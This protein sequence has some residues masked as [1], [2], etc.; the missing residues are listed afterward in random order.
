MKNKVGQLKE[1]CNNRNKNRL[2][3]LH[4]CQKQKR[5]QKDQHYRSEG[6][7]NIY[8]ELNKAFHVLRTKRP[9]HPEEVEL[10]EQKK[11][12]L[13][14][15]RNYL[16]EDKVLKFFNLLPE[17]KR[18]EDNRVY[19]YTDSEGVSDEGYTD[20][21]EYKAE[22]KSRN[23]GQKILEQQVSTH[24]TGAAIPVATTSALPS[25]E[26]SKDINKSQS[27]SPKAP[28]G[29]FENEQKKF[30]NIH[31]SDSTVL[32][33][34]RI[35]DQRANNAAKMLETV[36]EQIARYAEKE[37]MTEEDIQIMQRKQA[38]LMEKMSEF[39]EITKRVQQLVGLRDVSSTHL[40]LP[41]K[42]ITIRKS[43]KCVEELPKVVI[44]GPGGIEQVP[45]IIVCSDKKTNKQIT[46]QGHA[47]PDN[48]HPS[49]DS[50]NECMPYYTQQ[51][52]GEPAIQSQ[53]QILEHQIQTFSISQ[54][55]Y[56]IPQGMS[57]VP[58]MAGY[59][60][61]FVPY[62]S[63][64]YPW[65]QSCYQQEM[66]PYAVPLQPHKFQD[67]YETSATSDIRSAPS[68]DQ[69][70]DDSQAHSAGLTDPTTSSIPP[71]QHMESSKHQPSTLEK[72]ATVYT[73]HLQRKEGP[74]CKADLYQSMGLPVPAGS[75]P[76]CP[77]AMINS[78]AGAA[79]GA[80]G[81]KVCK[82]ELWKA[83]GGGGGPGGGCTQ[84]CPGAQQGMM[85]DAP[86]GVCKKAWLKSQ[87]FKKDKADMESIVKSMEEEVRSIQKELELVQAERRGLE[88]QKKL[89]TCAAASPGGGPSATSIEKPLTV[90]TNRPIQQQTT[91]E[92]EGIDRAQALE[93]QLSTMR[94]KYKKLQQD[95][96]V[97][98]E[99]ISLVRVEFDAA[100]R[101]A[102][103]LLEKSEEAEA[104]VDDLLER[105][106]AVEN[107]K[108]R[109][110]GSKDQMMEME[111]QLVLA[112]QR[113]REGQEEIE[114]MRT[115]MQ[116]VML[117]LEDYR[118]KY[119]NAQ[120][121]VEEQ[122][123]QLDI[124]ELENNRIGEQVNL[125]IQRVKTQFQ[126]KLQELTPLP[127]MLKATQLKLQETQQLRLIAERTAEQTRKEMDELTEKHQAL[128]EE[129]EEY[130]KDSS[131]Y[132]AEKVHLK[133]S[134]TTG[135]K[136]IEEIK[137]ENAKLRAT[138]ARLE[139]LALNN[140]RRFDE[141][142]HE[143][144]QLQTQ[145]ETLRE[146]SARQVARTKD[147]C[148]S[149]RRNLQSQIS[150]LERQLAQS[151]AAARTAQK[152]RDEIR[153]KMQAQ[154]T[155][156]N[157][158]FEQAQLRIRSLQSHVNYLKNSYT[159]IFAPEQQNVPI[160]SAQGP[161]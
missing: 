160:E 9:V 21:E 95:Y 38:E 144:L 132:D 61:P 103:A 24:P 137:S 139:E 146:E 65:G 34:L 94:E 44:C 30:E 76:N 83:M 93:C 111:Q 16:K 140:E 143:A 113:Y 6:R 26:A 157:D 150:E 49:M 112:K 31:L 52:T 98:V 159:N 60:E 96:N 84:G 133:N 123:R 125:E 134:L 68:G 115:N 3:H 67:F 13:R 59:P 106:K 55:A 28:M 1:E 120:Q 25:V 105:L 37:E 141:K 145:L 74:I 79:G 40:G 100:K 116:D 124:M 72:Q 151:R 102:M 33:E 81:G 32:E 131:N 5:G 91:Y 42:P 29:C 110:A 70:N 51:I 154:I 69:T 104:R 87:K 117:Q 129:L 97:K 118:N 18:M 109:I 77:A 138:V 108:M 130:K 43:D 50:Q 119:L 82:A 4:T 127:D 22:F 148:E 86:G 20:E 15:F 71:G 66:G 147:R 46:T 92:T 99:E 57:Q 107:E 78:L 135:E 7:T 156:L 121:T 19:A 122:R 152:D 53:P 85:G 54:G 17:N 48:L 14:V 136:K 88:L 73:E 153:Q 47:M 89:L 56:T 126:E 161:Y 35:A 27:K 11:R 8:D 23:Q 142:T 62:A 36:R 58:M 90:C 155:S 12:V 45:K 64:Q 101:D 41:N 114:E 39:E 158:N 75:N 80:P 2:S 10:G 149:V 128:L 63:Q